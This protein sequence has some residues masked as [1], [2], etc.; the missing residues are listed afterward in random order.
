MIGR[1]DTR[2]NEG[3]G[4]GINPQGRLEFWVGDGNEV[5]YVTAELPLIK[6]VWYF[7]AAS[8]DHE[9]G[10]ATLYQEAVL[11]RY[12]SLIGKVVPYDFS[13]HV[14]TTFRFRQKNREDVPFLV[15]G[16]QDFHELQR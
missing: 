5:D 12:N 2:R 8:F 15:A 7:V 11:N 9:T 16:A 1:W 10:T 6:N 14:Q 13:S 4:L 3:Y